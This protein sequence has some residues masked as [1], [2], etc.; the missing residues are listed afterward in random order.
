LPSIRCPSIQ[1][2]LSVL[3][4]TLLSGF[5]LRLEFSDGV[6]GDVDC[7]FLLDQGLGTALR[8]PEYFRQVA[9]DPELGTVVWPNGLDPAPS[10]LRNH[11]LVSAVSSAA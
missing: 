10:L 7:S 8:D 1:S 5:D 3:S 4:V 11:A 9:I 6:T 2:M